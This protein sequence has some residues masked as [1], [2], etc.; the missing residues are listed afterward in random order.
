MGVSY[1]LWDSPRRHTRVVAR[2]ESVPFRAIALRAAL[3]A[4][5][6]AVRM[7]SRGTLR[8]AFFALALAS[9]V[10]ALREPRVDRAI[11]LSS[12]RVPSDV[13]FSA[14]S[15]D[16]LASRAPSGYDE[17]EAARFVSLAGAAYCDAG[18]DTW[19]CLYCNGTRVSDV[20]VFTSDKTNVHGYVGWDDERRAAVVAFRGTEPSSLENWLE[21]LDA[22]HATWEI[23]ACGYRRAFRVHAGFL[24][25]YASVRDVIFDALTSISAARRLGKPSEPP[26]WH[27]RDIPSA[28]RS[29]R[30]PPSNSTRRDSA[31]TG[32]FPGTGTG[33]GDG[34]GDEG[35]GHRGARRRRVDLRFAE[36]RGRRVR[37]GVRGDASGAHVAHHARARRRPE[38]SRATDGV[39]PRPHGDFLRRGARGW[40]IGTGRGCA[41]GWGAA[42]G[43]AGADVRRRG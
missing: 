34:D 23:G 35:R 12:R 11:E 17:A 18:L 3:C 37:G 20:T 22:S 16:A 31:R 43:R 13:A 7:T 36:G 41:S 6:R 40:E 1:W 27:S 21:N 38:R 39:P 14:R 33:T 28:A 2:R 29:P 30:S 19:T 25:A 10:F 9:R 26:R 15:R 32:I 8:A 5:A 24:D 42:G 4:L